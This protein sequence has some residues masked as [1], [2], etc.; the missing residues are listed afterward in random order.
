LSDAK[1]AKY[2]LFNFLTIGCNAFASL[3]VTAIIA[4]WLAPEAMGTYSLVTF[5]FT[6][7]AILVNLGL[8]T[9]TM[10]YMAE[11]L[12]RDDRA[13]AGGI[14]AHGLRQIAL[15]GAIVTAG[16]LAVIPWV[17][18][19]Y[20]QHAL[21]AYMGVAAAVILPSALMAILTAALQGL[22]RYGQVAAAT[23]TYTVLLTI[24]TLVALL[25]GTGIGGLLVA[26]AV[27]NGVAVGLYLLFL[28]RW[29]PGWWRHA[30]Q[31]ERRTTMRRY[32]ASLMVLILLDAI[33]WQRSG[34]FFLGAW[35]PPKEVAFYAMAFGLA[36]M[37]MRM[38][39]GTLVG[40]LI[41]SMS[42]S[43][44]SGDMS[45]V[46]SIYQAAGRWMA[47]LALPV[48]VGG[49]ALGTPL[50]TALYGPA[51]APMA[52][53]LGVLFAAGALVM[54]FGFPAS[55]VLYA[56]EGQRYLVRVGLATAALNLV[57][58]LVLI[59]AHGAMGAAWATALSQVA[60]LVPGAYFAGKML[61]GV[62][63][64]WRR[65]PATLAAAVAMGVP[66]WAIGQVLPPVAAIAVGVPAGALIY[67]L[68]LW[69]LRALEPED[70][71]RIGG[72]AARLPVIKRLVPARV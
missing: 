52:Q 69:L 17:E 55:S 9:T 64:A 58:A 51:Y 38:I 8:V 60:S 35:A 19:A 46:A 34:V 41:P 27:A 5:F 39:P 48:A 16:W 72:V 45:Q 15:N 2:T 6:M 25:M 63:P 54:T 22:Q 7:A 56:V 37:A 71:R 13:E 43:F 30:V 70:W 59:P 61:G 24:G 53:V 3:V 36:T 66:V 11:A 65:F 20:H 31:T 68:N 33:V 62:A 57:L 29:Q 23:A 28:H 32:G 47:V 26:M 50:V 14:L 40:L 12:G 18:R 10:K 67:A 49:T 21:G 44:G 4:R 42:R 1:L